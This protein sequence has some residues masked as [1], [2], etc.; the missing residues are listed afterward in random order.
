MWLGELLELRDA[1]CKF[2][3]TPKVA[4]EEKVIKKK[5]SSKKQRPV[6]RI[7]HH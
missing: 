4:S 1:Y 2:V 7:L 6:F 3:E 5:K